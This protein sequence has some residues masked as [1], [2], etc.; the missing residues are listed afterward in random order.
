MQRWS[1]DHSEPTGLR[2]NLET[3][4][5]KCSSVQSWK[6]SGWEHLPFRSNIL[7]WIHSLSFNITWPEAEGHRFFFFWFFFK[8]SPAVHWLRRFPSAGHGV[9]ILFIFLCQKKHSLHSFLSDILINGGYMCL[10]AKKKSHLHVFGRRQFS[11]SAGL[12]RFPELEPCGMRQSWHHVARWPRRVS[13][14]SFQKPHQCKQGDHISCCGSPGIP[15]L[16]SLLSRSHVTHCF[17]WHNF[18]GSGTRSAG[19][20]VCVCDPALRFFTTF[21]TLTPCASHTEMFCCV[22]F[23]V[24]N[25]LPPCNSAVHPPFS[26]LVIF[27]PHW[28]I[29][30]PVWAFLFLFFLSTFCKI[31]WR[32]E[33]FSCEGPRQW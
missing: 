26:P 18:Q 10:S 7:S 33:G 8:C 6:P 17:D 5:N 9:V 25:L 16:F 11:K 15:P 31:K 2:R 30:N 20:L 29:Q 23:Y 19:S 27:A 21:S 24:L 3:L 1:W 14:K 32:P 4:E 28:S 12:L 22:L 13:P